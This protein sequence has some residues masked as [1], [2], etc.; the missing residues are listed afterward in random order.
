MNIPG[1]STPFN[2]ALLNDQKIKHTRT[3]VL[4]VV[5][6]GTSRPKLKRRL[7]ND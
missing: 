2:K 6:T 4:P 3:R 7:N 5:V 1:I